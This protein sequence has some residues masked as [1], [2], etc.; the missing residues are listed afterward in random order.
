M[1][2]K[3]GAG[4]TWSYRCKQGAQSLW[5]IG[6]S[7]RTWRVSQHYG[8]IGAALDGTSEEGYGPD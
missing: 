8:C 3:L 5:G 6:K 2:I 7:S 1:N 4:Q